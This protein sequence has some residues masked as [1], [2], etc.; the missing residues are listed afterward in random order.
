MGLLTDDER[1]HLI[2]LL[3]EIPS[4]EIK[5]LRDEL[6]TSLPHP[7]RTRLP[8]DGGHGARN[9]LTRVVDY[10]EG[11]GI[12]QEDGTWLVIKLIEQAQRMC[13]PNS[14]HYA[15]TNNFH[16]SVKERQENIIK[17]HRSVTKKANLAQPQQIIT[18][19]IANPMLYPNSEPTPKKEKKELN[20]S[21]THELQQLQAVG[22][23]PEQRIPAT[24][25]SGCGALLIGIDV[26]WERQRGYSDAADVVRAIKKLL[27][28]YELVPAENITILVG[29]EVVFATIK[30][31]FTEKSKS[32]DSLFVFISGRSLVE[33]TKIRIYEQQSY[34]SLDELVDWMRPFEDT[35]RG[36]CFILDLNELTVEA[37]SQVGRLKNVLAVT[38]KGPPGR[39]RMDNRFAHVLKRL[40]QDVVLEN[41]GTDDLLTALKSVQELLIG[42]KPKVN[43]VI[44][45]RTMQRFVVK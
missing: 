32:F 4:I 5:E 29:H 26:E 38:W 6:L 45:R 23:I 31:W 17:Q 22:V 24:F 2:E 39:R 34:L 43:R 36:I 27:E 42:R 20:Y 11:L 44:F 35:Q 16:E 28:A 3:L 7:I 25:L 15:N 19:N 13:T 14:K 37:Q 21:I 30:D 1:N 12:Q 9:H 10:I 40:P 41:I 18:D 8:E 33:H